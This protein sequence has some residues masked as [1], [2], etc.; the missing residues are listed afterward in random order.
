MIPASDIIIRLG[1]NQAVAV[2]LG[3]TR[4]AV[5][6]WQYEHPFGLGNRVPM[7]HWAAIVAKSGGKV[8]L[9]ELMPADFAQAL[10]DVQAPAKPKRRQAA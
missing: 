10:G 6:R 1:G 4:S 9:D 5:Q 3:I 8:T 7:R 2:L